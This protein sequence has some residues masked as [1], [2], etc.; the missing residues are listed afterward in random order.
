[1]KLITAGDRR[2][3]DVSIR[4]AGLREDL[5][6]LARKIMV[7]TGGILARFSQGLRGG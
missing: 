2:L 4:D 5:H 3:G 6:T 7:A 1:M